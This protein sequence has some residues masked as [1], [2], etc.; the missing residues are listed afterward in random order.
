M[1]VQTYT[2]SYSL[3]STPSVIVDLSNVVSFNMRQGREKQLDDYSADTAQV[4]IRYP[5]GYVSPIAALVPGNIIRVKHDGSG[6]YIYAGY[7]SGVSVNYGIP[8]AGGVGNE[9]FITISCE[10]Y[11]ARFGRLE[12]NGQAIT[13]GLFATVAADILTYSGLTINPQ[14]N[15]L[16]QSVSASTVSNTYGEWLAQFIRTINGRMAQAAAVIVYGPG[17]IVASSAS[18]SDT[19]NN[20]TN[21]VYDNIQFS[22]FGDNYYTQVTVTPTVPAAQTVSS[23]SGPYRSLKFNTFS[24]TTTTALNLANF[25]LSQYS[26]T[27]VQIYSISCLSEAQTSFKLNNMGVP[28]AL[29]IGMQ[30]PIKFRG[31][32]YYGIIEG[33]TMT[34]TPESS[35]WTYYISGAS[36]NST[37]IL[38]DAVFGKLGTGKLGY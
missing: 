25:M 30:V 27:D 32:T 15:A 34:A 3:A 2:V 6:E 31:T 33:F 14:A 1:S 22:A 19:A 10:S 7:I 17:D 18:F 26:T 5:T 24:S 29:L 37:L 13:G 23:G 11:F 12:G 38:D 36:L 28:T 8:Y 35:R 21:Q 20:A 16:T 9:D 4:I